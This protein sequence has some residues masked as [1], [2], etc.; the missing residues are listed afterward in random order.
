M[1]N[2]KQLVKTLA[3]QDNLLSI[4]MVIAAALEDLQEQINVIQERLDIIAEVMRKVQT[5]RSLY[6][7]YQ[8]LREPLRKLKLR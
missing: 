2:A 8:E 7:E 3:K 1:I 4:L 5:S 6:R